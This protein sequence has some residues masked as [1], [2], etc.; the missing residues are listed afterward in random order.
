MPDSESNPQL[1]MLLNS[2]FNL[3]DIQRGRPISLAAATGVALSAIH[4][5]FD[6]AA[7]ARR[8]VGDSFSHRDDFHAEFVLTQ[9][10]SHHSLEA[11]ERFLELHR[12][13][14]G[15]EAIALIQDVAPDLILLDVM[16]PG[17]T[18]YEVCQRLKGN[19]RWRHIPII[20]VTAL[21]S[22]DDLVRGLNSGADEFISKPVNGPEMR[23][24]VRSMIEATSDR[25]TPTLTQFRSAFRSLIMRLIGTP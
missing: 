23:A 14:N 5:R 24:R 15:M 12:A 20:L 6:A 13:R 17:I 2:T 21:D 18:G 8:N 11:V 7:I 3:V 10:V 16:M 22:K 1:R 9:V 19:D 25:A 4:I